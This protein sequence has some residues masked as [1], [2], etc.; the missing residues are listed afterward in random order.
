MREPIDRHE[1]RQPIFFKIRQVPPQVWQALAYLAFSHVLHALN[2]RDNYGGSGLN[3]RLFHYDVEIFLSSEVRAK[4][5][6]I[7]HIIR[8]PQAHL[9]RDDRACPMSNISERAGVDESRRA[10]CCL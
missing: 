5:S 4:A 9:L 6:F 10:L 7:D 2:C 1:Q 8:K 3:A